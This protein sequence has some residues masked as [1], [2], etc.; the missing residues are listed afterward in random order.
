MQ[1]WKWVH[2][3]SD[4]GAC[5]REGISPPIPWEPQSLGWPRRKAAPATLL[6]TA[7]M[8]PWAAGSQA[9]CAH[10]VS[11]F[12]PDCYSRAP[13]EGRCHTSFQSALTTGAVV[14]QWLAAAVSL[15]SYL[16]ISC[17]TEGHHQPQ[18]R[19]VAKGSDKPGKS[20]FSGNTAPPLSICCLP[21]GSVNKQPK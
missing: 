1:D 21:E 17:R 2:L 3:G 7:L 13:E 9:P 11:P 5:R 4:T 15:G 6:F 10:R 18:L 20:S 8:L 16:A 14:S 19:S 12:L